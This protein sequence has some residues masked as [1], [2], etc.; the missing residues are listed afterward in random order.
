MKTTLIILSLLL[1][2]YSHSQQLPNYSGTISKPQN[3]TNENQPRPFCEHIPDA[4]NP[5]NITKDHLSSTTK[6]Q[7]IVGNNFILDYEDNSTNT[8]YA[9]AVWQNNSAQVISTAINLL[10]DID[11]F[12][13]KNSIVNCGSSNQRIIVSLRPYFQ[14]WVNNN[15]FTTALGNAT[16]STVASDLNY[17]I[18]SCPISIP[19]VHLAFSNS[20]VGSV[21]SIHIGTIFLNPSISNFNLN[22]PTAP[23]SSEYDLYSVLLHELTH[24]LGINFGDYKFFELLYAGATPLNGPG[25]FSC[26]NDP[27]ILTL[28][29]SGC[30]NVSCIGNFVN[31]PVYAPPIFDPSSSLSHFPDDCNGTSL[32]NNVMNPGIMMGQMKRFY[33]Q[34]EINALQD[35][36]FNFVNPFNSQYYTLNNS[37]FVIGNH[38]GILVQNLL[39]ELNTC[40]INAYQPI[41]HTI[42]DTWPLILNPLTND[43]NATFISEAV[44]KTGNSN[45]TVTITGANNDQLNFTAM[46]PGI[47]TIAYIPASAS[48]TGNITY[49][50]VNVPAC[51]DLDLDDVTCN[52]A[53]NCNQ[54][55]IGDIYE[56]TLLYG[57]FQTAPIL[58][59]NGSL[60]FSCRRNMNYLNTPSYSSLFFWVN[61]DQ[62]VDYTLSLKRSYSEV[63]SLSSGNPQVKTYAYLVK[64][65]DM[66]NGQI[67]QTSSYFPSLPA[68]RQ[69]VYEE[70]FTADNY[71]VQQIALCFTANDEYDMLVFYDEQINNFSISRRGKVTI[72]DVE[73]MEK[74]VPNLPN[75]I[76]AC[77]PQTIT[78]GQEFCAAS[79]AT[80]SWTSQN[81][82]VLTTNQTLSLGNITSTIDE[83]YTFTIT[84]PSLP[85]TMIT[86]NPS[87]S[88]NFSKIIPVVAVECCPGAIVPLLHPLT[89]LSTGRTFGMDVD[90]TNDGAVYYSGTMDPNAT[91]GNQTVSCLTMN[92]IEGFLLKM[93]DFCVNWLV[94]TK[95]PNS[96][97]EVTNNG[98][99]FFLGSTSAADKYSYLANFNNSN[100]TVTWDWNANPAQ[101][102]ITDFALDET[103]N[104]ILV[105]GRMIGGS[106]N[107]LGT[108][109]TGSADDIFVLKIS[110]SGAYINHLII[111]VNGSFSES[112]VTVGNN[113]IF[114]AYANTSAIQW[115]L[116]KLNITTLAILSTPAPATI[117]STGQATFAF[118]GLKIDGNTLITQLVYSSTVM[119]NGSS[120]LTG[121]GGTKTGYFKVDVN[122]L[123]SPTA[124]FLSNVDYNLGYARHD[125]DMDVFNGRA[126][127]SYCNTQND[128]H[129]KT[130]NISNG[131][132]VWTKISA[133]LI[134]GDWI[135][136]T[137]VKMTP[138]G[139]YNTGSFYNNAIIDNSNIIVSNPLTTTFYGV[140]YQESNGTILAI[141][142]NEGVVE[143]ENPNKQSLD[144]N[145]YKLNLITIFPNPGTGLYT[146]KAEGNFQVI[147]RDLHGKIIDEFEGNSQSHFDLTNQSNGIYF[148]E[149]LCEKETQRF[150]LIKE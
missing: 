111:P 137:A 100:G 47:Y 86:P 135:A 60:E 147:I 131:A 57:D 98:R 124:S 55:C 104:T 5:G 105:T 59:S 109:I 150:K 49:I 83:Q 61:T 121:G 69:L 35:L 40:E 149:I 54:V 113:Q 78:L 29:T 19:N 138:S 20:A 63:G 119:Y 134:T 141:E 87:A 139:V 108:T 106:F 24:I 130:I 23:T 73:F 132:T 56:H 51:G 115:K 41:V 102:E 48:R 99:I 52:D 42:C 62:S 50:Q 94:R 74:N 16:Q 116:V 81:N 128:A 72:Q 18:Q 22:Y 91:F 3:I 126:A 75:E 85:P 10:E 4:H 66:L 64:S 125:V 95:Y 142:T 53:P 46:V 17:N 21:N 27:N 9:T 39:D 92:A 118:K 12:F 122:T 71:P 58:N 144:L 25:V 26:A 120:L 28:E 1:V 112:R 82:T 44:V 68:N 30:N 77:L 34:R 114:V 31:D 76:S 32:G 133:P 33:H 8:L 45:S 36:G 90:G 89:S 148:I 107:F 6:I 110:N 146:I 13:I 129:V 65:A 136:S 123:T 145:S 96:K 37:P 43:I 103:N 101:V 38:D 88:C 117:S 97:L 80:F 7:Y 70:L 79:T 127:F 2:F 143:N 93:D 14:N 140:K 67:S 15:L 84:Y 11:A